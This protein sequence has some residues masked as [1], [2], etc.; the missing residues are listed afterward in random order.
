MNK[1]LIGLVIGIAIAGGLAIYLNNAPTPFINKTVAPS[2]NISSSGPIILAPGTKIQ[3]AAS[4]AVPAA[5]AEASGTNYDFYEVLQAK[6][7][8]DSAKAT[9][10]GSSN[11]S[12]PKAVTKYFIQ[13]GAFGEEELAADMKGRLALMGIDSNIKSQKQSGGVVNKV[14]IG[15]ISTEENAQKIINQLSDQQINAVLIR[16]TK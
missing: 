9:A 16:I 7:V 10:S 14:L 12:A 1:F 11:A 13:A 2:G 5:K 3:E 6:K 15:P 8:A 4:E